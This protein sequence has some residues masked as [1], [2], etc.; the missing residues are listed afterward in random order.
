MRLRIVTFNAA[1]SRRT[2]GG[3]DAD[4]AAGDAQ[5]LAVAR[6]LRRLQPDVLL[7][8]ELDYT[9]C[10]TALVRLRR[11]YLAGS[12]V[13]EPPLVLPHA[14]T[15]AVNTGI[16]SGLDLDRDGRRDGP[17]D[18]LG[19]GAFPGQYG[20]ALL[21]RHPIATGARTLRRLLW[22]DV[23]GAYLPRDPD[24]GR[25]W[26]TPAALARLPLS[27]KSHWDIPVDVGGHR[28]RLLASHPTPPAFDG[29]E[30]RN[31]CRNHDELR[32][33]RD[34]LDGADYIVDDRG[35]PGGRPDH[36]PVVLLGDLNADPHD[37]NGD[38]AMIDALRHHP[39]LQDPAPRSTGGAARTA[40][41]KGDPALHTL[42]SGGFGL[43]VDYCLPDRRLT[44]RDTGVHWPAPGAPGHE[45][46]GD[47]RRVVSSDHRA[48]WLDVDWPP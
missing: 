19:F 24:S 29:P 45:L 28:L 2:P 3:L 35:D 42:A 37:G 23:P 9:P 21:S 31:H 36:A 26:Y 43:R 27:S 12:G 14:F 11:D 4:L 44:V 17:A 22:R 7:L 30:R 20:M 25:S 5:A 33:W 10:G 40:Q 46:V 15:A 18:A 48:V 41:A 6:I 39:T 8:N 38:A 16:P 34:Y 13:P 32:L 1:L 47:G